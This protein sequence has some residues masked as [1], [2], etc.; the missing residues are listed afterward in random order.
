MVVV[1]FLFSLGICLT[2]FF[3][4]IFVG[5]IHV[6][7]KENIFL[8]CIASM[9]CLNFISYNVRGIN[10]KTKILGSLRD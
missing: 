10:K 9:A 5:D 4:I 7:R 1:V 8:L 2:L 3:I 6:G